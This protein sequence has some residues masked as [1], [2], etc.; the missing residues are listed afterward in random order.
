MYRQV[1]GFLA[2][3]LAVASAAAPLEA[4]KSSRNGV[5]IAVT[6]LEVAPRANQSV[7]KVVLDTHS[8]DLADDLEATSILLDGRGSQLRPL[9]WE[10]APPGGHHREG[11]LTFP[12]FDAAPSVLELRIRRAGEPDARILKW[13]L[14]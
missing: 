1:I 8:Q 3:F 9:A 12:A 7:F 6:P 4:Q 2:L 5:T 10:G 14:E 13:K 11:I